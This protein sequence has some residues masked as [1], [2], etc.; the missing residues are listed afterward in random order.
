MEERLATLQQS[1][2][3]AN[4]QLQEMAREARQAE[5]KA[6]QRELEQLRQENA[7]MSTTETQPSLF[8]FIQPIL[9]LFN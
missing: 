2:E 3:S 7:I 5:V 6:M 4:S 8:E 9:R 1:I